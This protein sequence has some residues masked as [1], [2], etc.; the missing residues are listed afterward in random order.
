MAWPLGI[1]N[2][3]G[4]TSPQNGPINTNSILVY[5]LFIYMF[6]SHDFRGKLQSC[7]NMLNEKV[8][9]VAAGCNV[10]SCLRHTSTSF[11][12]LY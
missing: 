1:V 5:L 6:R 10:K 3:P 12:N 7:E 11:N 9:A 2:C 8:H 4:V